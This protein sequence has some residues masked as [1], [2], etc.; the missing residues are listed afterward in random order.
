MTIRVFLVDD[1]AIVR[2]G[3]RMLLEAQPDI[4][5]IGEAG[6]G[7]EAIRLAMPL[8]PDVMIV[9]ID[10]P[11]LNGIEVVHRVVED[12]PST[13]CLVLS[14]H[15]TKQHILRA[16]KA[17]VMGFVVKESAGDEVVDAVRAVHAGHRHLSREISDQVIA[18]FVSHPLHTVA[19][20]L[21]E[22]LT[23]REREVLQLLVEGLSRNDIA[24]HLSLSPKTVDTHRNNLMEKLGI[25]DLP[26][27]VKFA[28][29]Q[30]L[31]SLE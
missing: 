7:L 10:I 4:K 11:K 31:T 29:Q 9:D 18:D 25:N 23:Q 28:I 21:L 14:M 1:H 6:D 13:R 19:T 27:L 16:L 2:D 26:G 17:G 20:N 22:H 3:L 24:D 8:S 15:S 5:V 30:G 12:C